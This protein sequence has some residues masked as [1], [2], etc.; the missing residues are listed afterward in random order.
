MQ[1]EENKLL[2]FNK[3]HK[4]RTSQMS[5]FFFRN[6]KRTHGKILTI[7]NSS[8][9]SVVKKYLPLPDFLFLPTHIISILDKNHDFM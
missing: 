4:W 7:A 6:S 9:Y 5:F 8:F 2:L 1:E 3:C